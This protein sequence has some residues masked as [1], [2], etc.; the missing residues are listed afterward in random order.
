MINVI[1]INVIVLS[2]LAPLKLKRKSL[3]IGSYNNF[4]IKETAQPTP[5]KTN[6]LNVNNILFLLWKVLAYRRSGL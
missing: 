1:V 4:Q 6:H 3:S 5:S 2:V